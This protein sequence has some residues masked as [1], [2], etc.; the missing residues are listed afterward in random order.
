MIDPR[1]HV[2]DPVAGRLVDLTAFLPRLLLEKCS[3]D[4]SSGGMG[5]YRKL[6]S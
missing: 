6:R 4:L 5:H 2:I 1:L 3:D